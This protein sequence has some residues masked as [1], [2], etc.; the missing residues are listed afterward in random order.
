M[1]KENIKVSSFSCWILVSL[2]CLCIWVKKRLAFNKTQSWTTCRPIKKKNQSMLQ[3]DIC[4]LCRM[5]PVCC[6][7]E[8]YMKFL[9]G[10]V[11]MMMSRFDQYQLK[12]GSENRRLF[13]HKTNKQVSL[14][15]NRRHKKSKTF[16]PLKSMSL[17]KKHLCGK[18]CKHCWREQF[19]NNMFKVMMVMK[20]VIIK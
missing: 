20:I 5:R 18:T 7:T 12:W 16:L 1:G 13:L 2:N 19:Y 6:F 14:F 15:I 9:G 8:M 17:S 11:V 3:K 10:H 4:Y